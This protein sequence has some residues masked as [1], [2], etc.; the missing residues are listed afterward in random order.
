[1]AVKPRVPLPSAA[2]QAAHRGVAP[3]R[4]SMF[5]TAAQ[6]AQHR[7]VAPKKSTA[8]ATVHTPG[9]P[10]AAAPGPP[11]PGTAPVPGYQ[12]SLDANGINALSAR[13]AQLIRRTGKD[14]NGNQALD[15]NGNPIQGEYQSKYLSALSNLGFNRD[16]GFRNVDA[17]AAARGMLRSGI[18]E[19]DRGEVQAGYDTGASAAL[20]ERDTNTNDEVGNYGLDVAGINQQYGVKPNIEQTADPVAP[21]VPP[22][23][24]TPKDQLRRLFGVS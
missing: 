6:Q 16:K 9:A 20:A 13:R 21:A 18:R 3:P 22:R 17:G 24:P 7:G 14:E 12:P 1:M 11:P 8:P 23:G 2:Q 5:P 4:R 15:A 10:A 19:V